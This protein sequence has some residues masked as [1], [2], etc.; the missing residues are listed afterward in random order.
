MVKAT[1]RINCAGE[2]AKDCLVLSL[3]SKKVPAS[4]QDGD[5]KRSSLLYT[6][7]THQVGGIPAHWVSE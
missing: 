6:L 2:K 4:R 7:C 3:K 1:D 5:S